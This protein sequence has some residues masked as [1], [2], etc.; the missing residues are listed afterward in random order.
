MKRLQFVWYAL[1]ALSYL[2]A[3][4]AVLILLALAVQFIGVWL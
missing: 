2:L 3:S 1:A 4:C